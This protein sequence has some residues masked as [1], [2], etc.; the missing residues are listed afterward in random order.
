MIPLER[1]NG[2]ANNFKNFYLCQSKNTHQNKINTLLSSTV[3]SSEIN[4]A[5]FEQNH[6]IKIY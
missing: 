1:S 2:R 6:S 3:L 4:K 5:T